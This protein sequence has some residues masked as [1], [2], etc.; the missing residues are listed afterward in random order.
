VKRDGRWLIA[1]SHS[2]RKSALVQ[3]VDAEG[4]ARVVEMGEMQGAF[5]GEEV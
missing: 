3:A 1:E 5:A 2:V 4:N